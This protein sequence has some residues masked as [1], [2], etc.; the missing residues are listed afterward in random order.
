MDYKSES[1]AECL[2][3]RNERRSSKKACQIYI[4]VMA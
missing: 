3:R 4:I 1:A 2:L